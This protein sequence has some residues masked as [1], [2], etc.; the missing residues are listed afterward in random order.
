[1][2]SDLVSFWSITGQKIKYTLHDPRSIGLT[3]MH[4]GAQNYHWFIIQGKVGIG[5]WFCIEI[6]FGLRSHGYQGYLMIA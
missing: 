4:T 3:R 2:I 5:K 1:M 6:G